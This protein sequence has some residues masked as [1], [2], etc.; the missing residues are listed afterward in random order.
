[1]QITYL[2]F[3]YLFF[4]LLLFMSL[5][6]FMPLLGASY[7]VVLCMGLLINY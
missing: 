1:M 3:T 5:V 2:D 4:L 6:Q 7:S